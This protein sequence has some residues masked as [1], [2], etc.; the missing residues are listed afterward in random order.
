MVDPVSWY[1][2]EFANCKVKEVQPDGSIK[3]CPPKREIRIQ[4]LFKM[5]AGLNYDTQNENILRVV[6]ETNG[7]A[8]TREVVRAI[9]QIPLE[10]HPGDDFGYSLCHDVLACLVEVATGK[11]FADYVREEI[12]EPLGMHDTFYHIPNED[13]KNRLCALYEYNDTKQTAL[14]KEL[15]NTYVFGDEYDCGGAGIITTLDDYS[16]FAY[17][18]SNYGKGANGARI[19]SKSTVNLMRTNLLDGKALKSF[20]SWDTNPEYGY[21]YG[22]RTK[23]GEGNGGNISSIGEFGWDGA[24]GSLVCIDPE[25]E[26]VIVYFQH[27]LNP[28]NG[29]IH[30]RIRLLANLALGY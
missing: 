5:S 28:H 12:F 18:L 8:P 22:V 17:A 29:V 26:L 25:R 10:F 27:V 1:L 9:S 19:L 3:L 14:R 2:P 13:V 6:K 20:S 7:K 4:D 24:A 15:K 11:R 16:K 23:I 21:G 30:P